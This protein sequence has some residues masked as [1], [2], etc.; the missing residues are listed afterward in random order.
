MSMFQKS[1][2]YLDLHI[3]INNRGRFQKNSTTNVMTSPFISSNIP[4]SPAYAVYISHLIHYSEVC[5][6][7]IDFLDRVQMQTQKLLKQGYVS[8]SLSSSLQNF[9]GRH[10]DLIDQNIHISHDNSPFC[11]DVLYFF[12]PRQDVHRT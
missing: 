4:G 9:Y 11:V 6:Q 8:S 10:H 5:A 3:E 7:Y 12:H 1:A 2:T